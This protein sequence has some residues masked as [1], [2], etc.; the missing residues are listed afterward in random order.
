MTE[1]YGWD[2]RMQWVKT[3]DDG[4]PMWHHSDFHRYH[5][6][7]NFTGM[8]VDWKNFNYEK[9][10]HNAIPSFI[11]MDDFPND[12]YGWL[13]NKPIYDNQIMNWRG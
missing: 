3:G 13:L 11:L 5:D 7:E 6:D 2:E 1:Y 12:Y 9:W 8:N 10:K 4:G